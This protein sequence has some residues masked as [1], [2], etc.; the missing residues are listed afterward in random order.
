MTL[1][2]IAA[3]AAEGTAHSGNVQAETFVYGAV[4]FV[5][6]LVLGVV[7]L[8]FRNVAN[9]HSQKAEAYAQAHPFDPS[10]A[11]HGHH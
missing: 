3:L 9:R 10:Q 7:A 11:G 1:A 8:S 5:I 4:A 6:F 2:T